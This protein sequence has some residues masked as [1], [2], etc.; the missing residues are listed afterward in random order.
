MMRRHHARG[1]A[2]VA[3]LALMTLLAACGQ[4]TAPATNG[5]DAGLRALTTPSAT[6]GTP[7]PTAI[8]LPYTFP[9]QWLPAPDSAHL[10][11]QIGSFIFS[12]SSPQ[13][14]YVCGI[15]SSFADNSPATPPF[16]V[17][18]NTGGQSWHTS[19]GSAAHAKSA[20][21]LFIDQNKANDIFAAAGDLR[22]QLTLFR[23]QDGG[24]SWKAI[25][26]PTIT[27]MNT[28]VLQVAVVQ[29]RLIAMIGMNGEG[30]PPHSFYA[31]DDGG[32]SWAPLNIVV[33][34]ASVDASEQLWFDGPALIIEAAP[35]CAQGCGYSAPVSDWRG[36]RQRLDD[37]L[38]SQPPSPN[39]Y[40]QSTDGG[41]TWIPFPTPVNNL[42][43][44]TFTR[45]ADGSTTY[46]LGTATGVPNQPAATNVAFYSTDGGAH[47]RQL[48]T[49]AG[50]ENGY[51]DPG[52]LGTFGASVMP[53]GSVESGAF[54]TTGG[55]NSNVAGIFLMSPSDATPTWRP[56]I[57]L[58]DGSFWQAIP[59]TTGVRVWS[60]LTRPGGASGQLVYFDLP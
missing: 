31:S 52:S 5:A 36:D 58:A 14:G 10:P 39:Y 8:P 13:T 7:T 45:S 27:N 23:S 11:P 9:K 44:L 29:T 53:D 4:A 19:S 2:A 48:P 46:A 20:C 38:S 3:L 42:S 40:Y 57:T 41:R 30:V 22:G 6:S 59:T 21:A 18:T 16:V 33:N 43:N 50:V 32:K 60:T 51:L 25:N 28:I 49:L 15:T 26:Q 35:S 17:A 12:P 55:N 34:G 24:V 54:H 47:W 1:L 56:L 37:P